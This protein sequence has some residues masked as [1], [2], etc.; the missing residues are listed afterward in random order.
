MVAQSHGF[1]QNIV[2]IGTCD[3]STSSLM[4][5]R[6]DRPQDTHPSD[7]LPSLWPYYLFFTVKNVVLTH[8]SQGITPLQGQSPKNA[9][10][11]PKPVTRPKSPQWLTSVFSK[12]SVCS[13]E[14]LNFV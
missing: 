5:Q 7:L 8:S 6:D 4:M 10:R 11:F 2:A 9:V 3:S 13:E 1:G 12:L 14:F